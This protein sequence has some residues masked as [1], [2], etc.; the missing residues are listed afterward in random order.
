MQAIPFS[1]L[2]AFTETVNLDG[3]V[4]R[5]SFAWNY[6]ANYWSMSFLDA[7]GAPLVQGIR[8]VLNLDLLRQYPGRGLPPGMLYAVDPSDTIAEP[9][10]D[11]F[12]SGR[13]TLVYLTGAESAI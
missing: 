13:V 1:T 10:F 11:D 7:G 5:L 12:S 9:A 4:Y 3:Q 2:P 8:L 6:R